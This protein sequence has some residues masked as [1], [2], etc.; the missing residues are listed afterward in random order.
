[1]SC[2]TSAW[3]TPF[4]HE[5]HHFRRSYT[6]SSWATPLPHELLTST[7]AIHHFRMSNT[8]L[9]HEQS[10]ITWATPLP[11]DE[12]HF[13]MSFTTSTG[14]TY[15]TTVWATPFTTSSPETPS[16]QWRKNTYILYSKLQVTQ[17]PK[18]ITYFYVHTYV[19]ATVVL[20]EGTYIKYVLCKHYS[21]ACTRVIH[22]QK[23]TSSFCKCPNEK[24][25]DWTFCFFQELFD[26]YYSIGTVFSIL[27]TVNMIRKSRTLDN[28][29]TENPQ[30]TSKLKNKWN[31]HY[32]IHY[33]FLTPLLILWSIQWDYS[34]GNIISSHCPFKAL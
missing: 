6:T 7:G 3:A 5:L 26:L 29:F 28:L 11:H 12:H 9:P 27:L 34:Y 18:Q 8:P 14:T 25:L 13:R 30:K 4:P 2:T 10:T 21:T 24:W 31:D 16:A 1:M 33:V 17:E 23:P 20:G 19:T 22:T 15:T 32:R